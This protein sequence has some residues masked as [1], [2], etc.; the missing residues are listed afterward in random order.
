MEMA[1]AAPPSP[2]LLMLEGRAVA[3]YGT[4]LLSWPLLSFLPRGDGH[5]V[6]VLPGFGASDVS[7]Q[8][9]R[10]ALTR[11]GYDAQG[12]ELGRNMGMDRPLRRALDERFEQLHRDHGR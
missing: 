5:T 11:L 7:T 1:D 2:L 6:M 12:W 4:L 8:P 9:L 10:R 3:E